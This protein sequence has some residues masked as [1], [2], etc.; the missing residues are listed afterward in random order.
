M[1]D[2]YGIKNVG[3]VT[4]VYV[5]YCNILKVYKVERSCSSR[6]FRYMKKTYIG[7]EG[8]WCSNHMIHMWGVDL[9]KNYF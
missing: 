4:L 2:I 7:E 6:A 9:F 3:L 1:N 8:C 5:D